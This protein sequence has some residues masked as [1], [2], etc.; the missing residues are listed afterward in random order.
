[1]QIEDDRFTASLFTFGAGVRY[2]FTDPRPDNS[3]VY[4]VADVFT[5][6]GSIDLGGEDEIEEP[7]NGASSFGGLLGF[8]A[9]YHLGQGFALSGEIGVTAFAA[10]TATEDD[11][12]IDAISRRVYTSFGFNFYL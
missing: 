8:G 7:V 4:I 1:L 9:E 11:D 3:R 12:S 2:A 6:A 5:L 10:S